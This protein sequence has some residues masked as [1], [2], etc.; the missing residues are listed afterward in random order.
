LSLQSCHL[1]LLVFVH[2]KMHRIT[3]FSI[4]RTSNEKISAVRLYSFLRLQAMIMKAHPNFKLPKYCLFSKKL[5]IIRIFC[6]SL[7][8]AVPINPYKCS[9]AVLQQR[10]LWN[11]HILWTN[12]LI[13]LSIYVVYKLDLKTPW[14]WSKNDRN[15]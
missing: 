12:I 11:L 7:C 14:R 4:L 13:D 2:I 15:M 1:K 3:L 8:L 10:N 6:I 5:P 9:P